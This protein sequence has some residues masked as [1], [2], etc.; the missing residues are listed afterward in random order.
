[1]DEKL[2]KIMMTGGPAYPESR[3]LREEVRNEYLGGKYQYAFTC[4]RCGAQIKTEKEYSD[5][6]KNYISQSIQWKSRRGFDNLFYSIFSN[7]PIVGRILYRRTSE[8][9][10]QKTTEKAEEH[11]SNLKLKA[12]EEVKSKF[13]KCEVCGEYACEKCYQDGMCVFCRMIKESTAHIKKSTQ[14]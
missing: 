12:F 2:S 3:S 14:R 7:I 4:M 11:R 8:M 1:M 10:S 9:A 13:Y 6:S 5:G